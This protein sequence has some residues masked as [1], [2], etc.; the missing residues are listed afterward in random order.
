[1]SLWATLT[2]NSPQKLLSQTE[3][4]IAS[5]SG[6]WDSLAKP[7]EHIH[8][9]EGGAFHQEKKG[10][11]ALE[12]KEGRADGRSPASFRLMQCPDVPASQPA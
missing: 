11:G 12:A 1:M 8:H 9:Q 4:S 7:R 5:R 10:S 2:L 3:K 6:F